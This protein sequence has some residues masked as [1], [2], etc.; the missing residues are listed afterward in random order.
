[1]G[2]EAVVDAVQEKMVPAAKK[3]LVRKVVDIHMSSDDDSETNSGEVST[4]TSFSSFTYFTTCA[5]PF[6][7]TLEVLN[8]R[9]GT[10]SIEMVSSKV[11]WI[12]LR[13]RLAQILDAFPSSL[14]VQYRLSIEPK[15]LPVDLES[16]ADLETM[17]KLVEPL[18]VPPILANGRRSK[19]KM[20]DVK[21]QI[22]SKD[23]TVSVSD[24]V[25]NH[26]ITFHAHI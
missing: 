7:I 2:E 17:L 11:A 1:L 9:K 22:F 20:K 25:R 4:S 15:A 24:K 19:R 23:D 5:E 10:R 21:V 14:R 13:D 18:I 6:T 8:Q 12:F 26:Q 16:E 3:K